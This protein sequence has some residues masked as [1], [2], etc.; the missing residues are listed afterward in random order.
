MKIIRRNLILALLLLFLIP[1]TLAIDPAASFTV[2]RTGNL[3]VI[4]QTVYFND[5]SGGTLLES[6]NLSI[7]GT[8]NDTVWYNTTVEWGVSNYSYT[9]N[10]V[11]NFTPYLIVTGS[12]GSSTAAA[13]YLNTSW[14]VPTVSFTTNRSGN[15]GIYPQTVLFTDTSTNNASTR[16]WQFGEGNTSTT[17]PVAYTYLFPGNFSANLTAY[18]IE[19]SALSANVKMNVSHKL[20]IALFVCTRPGGDLNKTYNLNGTRPFTLVCNATTINPITAWDSWSWYG[21]GWASNQ[22]TRNVSVTFTYGGYKSVSL[23]AGNEAGF[24]TSS[25]PARYIWVAKPGPS[26]QGFDP[27]PQGVFGGFWQWLIDFFHDIFGGAG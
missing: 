14:G 18:S 8:V 21:T 2:N 3:G 20:P 11:G 13:E 25:S 15:L 24:N 5:T 26:M 27:S 17:S 10:L 6:W 7:Q 16:L 12:L 23:I 9:Y 22:T 19:G 1:A 4:P